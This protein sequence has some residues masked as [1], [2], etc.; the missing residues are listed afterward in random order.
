MAVSILEALQN[1]KINLENVSKIG[2]AILPLAQEQLNNAVGLLEKGYS[3]NDEVETI[4]EK[5]GSVED[6][7]DL[8]E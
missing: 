5:Y 3:L 8:T 4:L 1:A 7:P 6:A 2:I